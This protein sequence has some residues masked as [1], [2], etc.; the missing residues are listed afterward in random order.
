MEAGLSLDGLVTTH[1]AGD[2]WRTRVV[3]L[4]CHVPSCIFISTEERSNQHCAGSHPLMVLD[5]LDDF[6]SCYL[7]MKGTF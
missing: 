2:S 4:G 3:A 7:K 5:P 6:A 1:A